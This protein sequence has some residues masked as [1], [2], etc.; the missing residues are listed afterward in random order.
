VED[1]DLE[2]LVA[3][4]ATLATYTSTAAAV[5]MLRRKP[6]CPGS[7]RLPF[8]ATIPVAALLVTV[9]LAA[10]ATVAELAAGVVAALVGYVIFKLRRESGQM[11]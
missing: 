10:S 8:G 3:R 5:A 11:A 2:V 6:D 1:E 7:S 9:A 4:L